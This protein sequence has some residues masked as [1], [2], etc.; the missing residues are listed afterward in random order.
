MTPY[1]PKCTCVPF[2]GVEYVSMF[3]QSLLCVCSSHT[4]NGDKLT[5]LP[6]RIPPRYFGKKCSCDC[7]CQFSPSWISQMNL[8]SQV[9]IKLQTVTK[10]IEEFD[11]LWVLCSLYST[12]FQPRSTGCEMLT[13][14]I[15]T[16]AELLLNCLSRDKQVPTFYSPSPCHL[17]TQIFPISGPQFLVILH[18]FLLLQEREFCFVIMPK[19]MCVCFN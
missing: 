11:V 13:V 5:P 8:P 15:S 16:W 3:F 6:S 14:I 12:F 2:W 19:L 18:I 7:E 1:T 9:S 17:S 10:T 4:G